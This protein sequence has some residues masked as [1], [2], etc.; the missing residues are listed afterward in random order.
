MKAALRKGKNVVTANKALLA[1][2]YDD[3]RALAAEHHVK[4][5]ASA[6]VGGSI[7]W[8]ANLERAVRVQQISQIHGIFNG[9]CN[10]ILD[11]MTCRGLPYTEVLA[12]AQELGYAEA[13]PSADV[14]GLDTAAK[15]VISANI[16]FG[17]S[18]NHESVPVA[19]IRNITAG[20]IA[21]FKE[22][23]YVCKLFGN[24]GYIDG[25]IEA[26]VQPTLVRSS[27][28]EAAVTANYNLAVFE[29]AATGIQS[30]SG[31]GAGRYPT[32]YNVLQDLCDLQDGK[33]FHTSI[34]P[35]TQTF[36]ENHT[37]MRY[38][39]RGTQNELA[40]FPAAQAA[41]Q[42]GDGI[43]T[44]ALPISHVHAW[45]SAHPTAFAAAIRE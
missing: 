27:A 41:Q 13:D 9:T 22:H 31:Q 36:A 28:S 29:G 10:Y 8:L 25:R 11:Q 37:A 35:H 44:A 5:R 30:F 2:Q 32:A 1:S 33:D 24:A 19:G 26:Y 43:L 34:F 39:I 16:A 14:D 7:G 42:W 3:L 15:L 4:I 38:Y 6:A 18:L 45:I 12:K 20:D 21:V 17:I 23:G 40:Q